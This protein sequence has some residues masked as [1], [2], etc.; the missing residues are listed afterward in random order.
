MLG[1]VP[2]AHKLHI[3]SEIKLPI[4]WKQGKVDVEVEGA[5]KQMGSLKIK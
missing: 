4:K 1:N 3:H 2:V 5:A